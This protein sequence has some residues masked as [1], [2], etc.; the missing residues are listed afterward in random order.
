MRCTFSSIDYAKAEA[1]LYADIYSISLTQAK[2]KFAVLCGYRNWKELVSSPHGNDTYWSRT[3]AI[4]SIEDHCFSVLS[5]YSPI[6]HY[7]REAMISNAYLPQDIRDFMV[8]LRSRVAFHDNKEHPSFTFIQDNNDIARRPIGQLLA[9]YFWYGVVREKSYLDIIPSQFTDMTTL[10]SAI[11]KHG[12]PPITQNADYPGYDALTFQDGLYGVG[13]Y[14]PDAPISA[15]FWNVE[16]MYLLNN[17]LVTSSVF[18]VLYH[19]NDLSRI[20]DETYCTSRKQKVR[21]GCWETGAFTRFLDYNKFRCPLPVEA[22]KELNQS[23]NK[24]RGHLSQMSDCY[25]PDN[26]RFLMA[27]RS[28]MDMMVFNQHLYYN[29]AVVSKDLTPVF[30][31]ARRNKDGS[32]LQYGH[33][34][35]LGKL[36]I[37]DGN[38]LVDAIPD[39]MKMNVDFF[40]FTTIEAFYAAQSLGYI[41]TL[42]LTGHGIIVLEDNA[43]IE[44]TADTIRASYSGETSE[45]I[46]VTT[47]KDYR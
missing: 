16:T 32:S 33:M 29:I 2:A 4:S 22:R 24:D 15:R 39:F 14:M 47:T 9:G 1:R 46:L 44:K 21:I 19:E 36:L 5:L 7:V 43:R 25:H 41:K 6:A 18:I 28:F 26:K 8:S 38:G 17:A 45:P 20:Q 30:F 3:T 37:L 13:R 27:A 12:V 40:V 35:P 11:Q 42:N 31:S 34:S 23:F 10:N